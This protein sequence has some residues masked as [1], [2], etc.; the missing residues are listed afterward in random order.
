M[1]VLGKAPRAWKIVL[2]VFLLPV[3]ATMWLIAAL[4]VS[5]M[6]GAPPY[7]WWAS[8][9]GFG[10]AFFLIFVLGYLLSAWAILRRRK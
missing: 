10:T 4:N 5:N 2:V 3:W 8:W 1:S 9:G 6:L 7:P